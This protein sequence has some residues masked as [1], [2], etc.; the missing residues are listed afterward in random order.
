MKKFL[1]LYMANAA[2]METMMKNSTPEQ[3][4]KGMEAWMKWMGDNKA[5]MVDGGAPLGKSKM[6][7]AKGASDTK[8]DVC[9]YSIVQA[10]AA[11]AA[12]KLF[13]KD[14]PHLQMPGAWVE[15][16]EVMQIPGM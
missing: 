11:E 8:N 2:D 7:D 14:H 12:T 16:V 6:V 13:G 9:G 5:S 1:V 4:Q 15:V 10:D 3:R